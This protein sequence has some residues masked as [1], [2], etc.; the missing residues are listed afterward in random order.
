M[1]S[2]LLTLDASRGAVV[3]RCTCGYRSVRGTRE[4]AQLEAD[5]HRAT[6]HRRQA[7]YVD[8]KRRARGRVT[9]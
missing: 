4:A 7:T 3:I 5:Q 8:S 6:A 1:A 2:R 9:A